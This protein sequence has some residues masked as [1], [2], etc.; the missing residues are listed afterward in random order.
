MI[1]ILFGPPGAG[2]GTQAKL[3]SDY[4]KIPHI[5]TGDILRQ[6][7]KD[8]SLLGKKAKAY[9]DKGELVPDALVTDMIFERM[10]RPDANKGFILDGYPRNLSQ[11]EALDKNIK[12]KNS[13]I[14]LALY[15]QTSKDII[16]KR[17]SGRRVCRKCG[18][19]YH[20][21]NMPP[22]KDMICDDCG[23]ELYQRE[24][25]KEETVIN[26]LNVYLKQSTPVLDYYKKQNKL[27]TIN[28]DFAAE[29]VF[30]VIEDILGARKSAGSKK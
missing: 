23:A 9:M 5:S 14:D 3:L 8:G 4:L 28:S 6:H 10:Q 13:R 24:D 22:K 26:R 20:L 11:A 15:F 29:V 21:V 1:L 25:D 16:V 12:D 7:V 19:N 17:L 18:R 27:Q 30:K 2:K